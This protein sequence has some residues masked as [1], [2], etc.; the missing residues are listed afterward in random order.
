MEESPRRQ[1]CLEGLAA[2]TQWLSYL[3]PPDRNG[4]EMFTCEKSRGQE[5]IEGDAD[6]IPAVACE[7]A[8]PQ[9]R[10]PRGRRAG[11]DDDDNVNQDDGVRQ[12]GGT[13]ETARAGWW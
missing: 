1:F 12:V 7:Q 5:S 8:V 2:A 9:S 11:H 10:S 6:G 13:R 3:S 4:F